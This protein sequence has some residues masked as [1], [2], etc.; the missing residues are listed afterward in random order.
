MAYIEEKQESRT[1]TYTAESGSTTREYHLFDYVDTSDALAALVDYVPN[2]IYVH[3]YLCILPEFEISPVFSDPER[4]L[5]EATATWK[6][7]DIAS[8]GGGGDDSPDDPKEPEDPTSFSFAFSGLTEVIQQSVRQEL[9]SLSDG[10]VQF[11]TDGSSKSWSSAWLNKQHPDLPPEGV[12]VNRPITTISA[13]TVVSG[14]IATNDW[15]RNRMAQVWTTNDAVWRGLEKHC[16]MF[17][18]MDGTKRGDGHWDIT[19]NFEYRP[20]NPAQKFLYWKGKGLNPSYITIPRHSGWLY[21]DANYTQ[22]ADDS[23]DGYAKTV[24]SL[25]EVLLHHIYGES[26]FNNLGMVGV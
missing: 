17:T 13:K 12:E 10:S 5:Y 1:M 16:V 8:G 21:V 3:N 25:D 19:Y 22:V 18:G 14:Y 4:T 23:S 6:T 20:M 24:R 9:G 11:N 2:D 15:F 26:D 7:A